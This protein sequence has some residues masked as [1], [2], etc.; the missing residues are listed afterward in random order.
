MDVPDHL[1]QT[2]YDSKTKI[3]VFYSLII[4]SDFDEAMLI[5][6]AQG[7]RLTYLQ[8]SDMLHYVH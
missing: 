5:V 7:Q 6:C 4:S 8:H 1:Y 2:T 3:V